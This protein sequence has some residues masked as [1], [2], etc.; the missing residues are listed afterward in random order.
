MAESTLS[1]DRNYLQR[2]AARY[3]VGVTADETKWST[4]ETSWIN[5]CVSSGLRTFYQGGPQR[6]Q[7]S[8][9]RPLT[10]LTTS[11][12]YSTGTVTIVNG[13][14]TGSGT[15]FPSWAA[16]GEITVGGNTYTIS[17]RDSDTQL[18]MDDTSSDN[19][20][21]AGTSYQLG[22]PTYDLAD[23]VAYITGPF[24]YRPGSATLY[25][26]IEQISV[27]EVR[28]HRQW[29]D[30]ISRPQA[31]TIEP[32]ANAP[33]TGSPRWRVRFWPTPDGA[34]VLEYR[35]RVRLDDID[36]TDKYPMASEEHAETI[37]QAVLA[38]CELQ[39]AGVEGPHHA[40]FMRC[41]ESS[42]AIDN[43]TKAEFLGYNHDR[44]EKVDID[45]RLQARA[46][47]SYVTYEGH[48]L[49]Y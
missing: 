1:M 14:V 10:T 20:V 4:E 22:R 34:Y 33:T 26:P 42:I 21:A 11:A 25:G 16:Q 8:F 39:S 44:S 36:D 24:T 29:T 47:G 15:V 28:S 37:K 19:D 32:L 38:E 13:V 6:H 5:D 41:M 3:L 35:Y 30:V 40:K 7:W 2:V 23:N 49:T 18:T 45:A 9:L 27:D 43:E 46:P 12:S 31:Y 17:T 48:N